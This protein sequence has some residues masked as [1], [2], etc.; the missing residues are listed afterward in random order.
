M[1]R[2]RRAKMGHNAAVFTAKAGGCLIQKPAVQTAK[3]AKY[4]KKALSQQMLLSQKRRLDG[5]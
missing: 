1:V 5:R 4:S 3:Y 2:Y